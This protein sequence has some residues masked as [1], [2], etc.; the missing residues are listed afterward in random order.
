MLRAGGA[1]KAEVHAVALH[2]D[3][4]TVTVREYFKSEESGTLPNST[5]C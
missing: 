2:R 4:V 1:Q 5:P 3:A